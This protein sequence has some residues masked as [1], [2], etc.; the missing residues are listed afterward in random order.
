M[1]AFACQNA[2]SAR[3]V[4]QAARASTRRGGSLPR[5]PDEHVAVA[6]PRPARSP[7]TFEDSGVKPDEAFAALVD[8]VLVA[9]AAERELIAMRTCG[10]PGAD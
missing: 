3:Q 9:D 5:Q 6:L 8:L 2:A 7:E 4:G 10:P 1:L